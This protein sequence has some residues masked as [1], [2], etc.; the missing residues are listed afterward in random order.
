MNPP[1]A[2]LPA[3]DPATARPA[4]NPGPSWGYA[5][6]QWAD[7]WLPAGLFA[8]GVRVGVLIAVLGMPAQRRHSAA[9]LTQVFGRPA[10]FRE[11]F[12]HF[13]VFTQL[14]LAKLRAGGGAPHRCEVAPPGGDG[15][16]ALAHAATPALFGTMHFGNSDLLG[17][18][19]ADFQK[20]VAVVRL[21]VG[22]SRDTRELGRRFAE[23]V[24]FL[25]VNEPENIPFALKDALAR[26]VS[27][28]MKCDRPEFSAKLEAFDFLG[29]RR[30]FPFTIYH[31]A[32]VFGAPVVHCVGV[33]AARDATLVHTSPVFRP[34]GDRRADLAAARAH[35]QEFLR[36]V[37]E[38]LR[39]DP[40]L[41]FNFSPLNPPVPAT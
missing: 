12:H 39:R 4:R 13:H 30:L 29:A 15:F 31:L 6:L 16:F 35:F 7:R 5:F 24:E 21:R 9:Y 37:E 1:A 28:A 40:Y 32:L 2:T 23:W 20:R 41:W 19:L 8:F 18:L 26:G 38:L 3:A 25:W 34:T 33:P 22:N 10:R 17:F 11:V 27:V 14:L 36:T